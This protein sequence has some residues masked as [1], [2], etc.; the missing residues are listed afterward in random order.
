MIDKI[1]EAEY[2][3]EHGH[4]SP[5]PFGFSGCMPPPKEKPLPLQVGTVNEE[6]DAFGDLCDQ[7]LSEQKPGVSFPHD[8]CLSTGLTPDLEAIALT[9]YNLKRGLKEFGNDGIVALGKEME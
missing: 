2:E 1:L 6:S 5:I 8:S 9:Q 3:Q 7:L 4:P